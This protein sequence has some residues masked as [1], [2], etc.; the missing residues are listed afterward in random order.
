MTWV[1]IERKHRFAKVPDGAFYTSFETLHKYL[2]YF[3]NPSDISLSFIS[4]AIGSDD[5]IST[6]DVFPA[7][8]I[9]VVVLNFFGSILL[10]VLYNFL[11]NMIFYKANILSAL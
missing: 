3:L 2:K 11:N 4:I 6:T 7:M 9:C 8:N 10:S 5:H 1:R